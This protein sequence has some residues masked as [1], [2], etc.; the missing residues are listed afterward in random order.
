LFLRDV[1]LITL[2]LVKKFI[3]NS[4]EPLIRP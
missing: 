1:T 2:Y 3:D 4:S